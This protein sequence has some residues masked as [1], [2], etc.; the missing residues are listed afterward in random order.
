[1]KNENYLLLYDIF[2]EFYHGVKSIRENNT[3]IEEKK[4]FEEDVDY[5]KNNQHLM[6]NEIALNII[7]R[8]QNLPGLQLLKYYEPKR[9]LI[10]EKLKELNPNWL[11]EIL[12]W[13][14]E[15]S[16]HTSQQ[17]KIFYLFWNLIKSIDEENYEEVISL[18]NEIFKY[19]EL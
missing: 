15:K 18:K 11:E 1:M 17:Y 3:L 5:L 12:Y 7:E 2:H 4:K 16:K 19:Q 6:N 8:V 10:V 9:K 13:K 14:K